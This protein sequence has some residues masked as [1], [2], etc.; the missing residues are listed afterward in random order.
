MIINLMLIYAIITIISFAISL[1]LNMRIAITVLIT[2]FSL[3]LMQYVLG[4]VGL[5]ATGKIFTYI[6]MMLCFI[7]VVYKI[8]KEKN[9]K[10]FLK[11]NLLDLLVFFITYLVTIIVL[12]D[13]MVTTHNELS[14]WALSVKEMLYNN[15]LSSDNL[16]YAG[17]PPIMRVWGYWFCNF[18][19]DFKDGYIYISNAILQAS[20]VNGIVLLI[21]KKKMIQSVLSIVLAN[22][23]MFVTSFLY[24][25]SLFPD[26]M[27]SLLFVLCIAYMYDKTKLGLTDVVILTVVLVFI[28][29]TKEI[30]LLFICVILLYYLMHQK[31]YVDKKSYLLFTVIIMFSV[32]L[33]AKTTWTTY[34]RLNNQ[35]QAWDMSGLNIKSIVGFLLGKGEEYQYDT[36]I[37]Y[38]KS[39]CTSENI[40]VFKINLPVIYIIIIT[41]LLMYVMYRV[42]NNSNKIKKVLIAT[43]VFDTVFIIGLLVMYMFSFAEFEAKELSAFVRYIQMV[44]IINIGA[45][46]IIIMDN[47]LNSYILVVTIVILQLSNNRPYT[48]FMKY[49]YN[50]LLSLRTRKQYENIIKYKELF[51]EQDKIYIVTDYSNDQYEERKRELALL[52][53]RYELVPYKTYMLDIED[54]GIDTIIEKLQCGYTYVYFNRATN[55]VIEKYDQ[56]LS[57]STE[58]I[59]TGALFKII[60]IEDEIR[61][62][63]VKR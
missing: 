3:S 9:M 44:D 4:I 35:L 28:E 20:I 32:V 51:N 45:L 13:K 43:M 25:T 12:K 59:T 62:E 48:T 30:G 29:L 7:Y 55:A 27:L 1:K 31:E 52:N 11:E 41:L 47:N 34:L 17:Y 49:K 42:K 6:L 37:K 15:V 23:M 50:N 40:K 54:K 53:I 26:V 5:L 61:I 14:H 2:M 24:Y 19:S 10:V 39:I 38:F 60:Y 57:D 58:R 56:L 36:V 22:V 33:L 63:K 16:L 18:F 46:L 21:C 8:V